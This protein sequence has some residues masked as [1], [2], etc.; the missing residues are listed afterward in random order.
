MIR[1]RK[2]L[3]EIRDGVELIFVA[4]ENALQKTLN[5]VKGKGGELPIRIKV[6]IDEKELDK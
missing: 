4:E 6:K 3:E 2:L 1:L 5:I